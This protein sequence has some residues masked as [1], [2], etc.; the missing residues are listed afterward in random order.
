[1][2][3][4]CVAFWNVQN[5]F[6]PDTVD[7]GPGTAVELEAKIDQL[8]QVLCRM[9]A[10]SPPDLIG[11]AEVGSE[12]I[13]DALA[14]SLP[15]GYL[16][17]WEP[18][19]TDDTTGLGLLVR[20]GVFAQ[21]ERI[22]VQ[23]PT[24]LAR[25]RCVVA[26]CTLQGSLE[27]VLVAVNHWKSR[28]R[29]GIEDP[30]E[31]RME[32]AR[33][34]GDVLVNSDRDTCVVVIGDF[35]AEPFERPFSETA[36]RSVRYFSTALWSGATPAYLYNTAWRLLAEPDLWED[37][38]AADGQVSRPR[39]S[40]DA[41]PAVIIDQLLVSGRALRGGPIRLKEASDRYHVDGDTSIR[42][43]SG[44]LVPARWRYEDAGSFSGSS[45]H[46][47]LLAEFGIE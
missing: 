29:H 41:S 4:L 30:E 21:L 22:A 42:K 24:M 27:S 40:H 11:L 7:R 17:L 34:L 6:E 31:D 46:F 28:L 3:N 39:T 16:A 38:V 19:Y 1:M 44:N 9:N 5:L 37:L 33:W 8:V 12:R 26:R 10:G 43:G 13:F 23:R 2:A 18:P 25:P 14:E 20:Q 36:L 15:G 47:P 45:D 35:N 32:T